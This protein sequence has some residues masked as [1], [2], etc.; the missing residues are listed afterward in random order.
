M[1][2]IVLDSEAYKQL[3][4]E[5]LNEFENSLQKFLNS[6]NQLQND[7][8]SLTEAQKLLPLKSK[9]S[10]QKLRDDGAIKFSQVGRKILY[11]RRSILKYLEDNQVAG[12]RV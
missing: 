9:T 4:K 5:I 6:D 2:V 11:S 10:W 1:E 8:I 7:W 12:W 3:K